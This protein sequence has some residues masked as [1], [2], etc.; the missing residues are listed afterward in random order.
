M[1]DGDSALFPF[2]KVNVEGSS[3]FARS[4]SNGNPGRVFK[5]LLRQR[6]HAHPTRRAGLGAVRTF[7][8]G[9]LEAPRTLPNASPDVLP[10]ALS[11]APRLALGSLVAALPTPGL[12]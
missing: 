4:N 10:D 5:A 7:L 2:A 9:S 1:S 12:A 6:E 3:P 11:G 8:G